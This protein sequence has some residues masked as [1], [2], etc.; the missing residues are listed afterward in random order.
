MKTMDESKSLY[1]GSAT[2][3]FTPPPVVSARTFRRLCADPKTRPEG[4][5]KGPGR[6]GWVISPENWDRYLRSHGAPDAAALTTIALAAATAVAKAG[7]R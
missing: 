5:A 7:Y 6:V 3:R 1:F 2:S 4:A